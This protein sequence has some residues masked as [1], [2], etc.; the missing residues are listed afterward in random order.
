MERKFPMQRQNRLFVMLTAA[1]VLVLLLSIMGGSA[2]AS[3]PNA[4]KP[5]T[6]TPTSTSTP[7]ITPTPTQASGA[8][9]VSSTELKQGWSVVSANN[10]TDTGPAISQPGYN[11]SRW[12]PITVPST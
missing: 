6:P 10:V 3:S 7:T 5:K 4:P 9:S 2:S 12:Y 1:L 8:P 11:V